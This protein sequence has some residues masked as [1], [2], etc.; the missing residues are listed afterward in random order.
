MFGVCFKMNKNCKNL[1]QKIDRS[2][3]C[4][5]L[6]RKI[7]FRECSGC[8]FKEY[9]EGKKISVK[10]NKT[11]AKLE[12]DRFSILTNDLTKCIVC[13]NKKEHLHE[14]YPGRNR[15]NSMKYGCVLPLCSNCHLEIHN[16]SKLSDY[17]KALTQQRFIEVYPYLDFIEIFKRNYL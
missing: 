9:N 8:E 12:R 3:Y 17:Y 15:S 11:I 2:L 16:N 10:K 4:K 6:N 14:V 5:M 1:K 7:S 13:E